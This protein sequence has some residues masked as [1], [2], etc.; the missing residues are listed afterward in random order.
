MLQFKDL[1]FKTDSRGGVRAFTQLSGMH[2]ISVVGGRVAYSL[3]REDFNDV[4][5]Y[6]KFEVAVLDADGEFVTGGFFPGSDDDVLGWQSREDID[7]LMEKIQLNKRESKSETILSIIK[8]VVESKDDRLPLLA[9]SSV[10]LNKIE[11]KIETIDGEITVDK[12]MDILYHLPEV[13]L[14][15]GEYQAIEKELTVEF[16]K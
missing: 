13:L 6:S 2:F 8:N 5:Q 11:A 10:D 12:V 7:K 16:D 15:G 14:W 4:S 3:P 1:E 9:T